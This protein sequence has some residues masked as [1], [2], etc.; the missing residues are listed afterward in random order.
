M[1]FVGST[2]GQTRA[3]DRETVQFRGG[4]SVSS[5]KVVIESDF[6]ELG[7]LIFD[8]VEL[9]VDLVERA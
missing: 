4:R 7:D 2:K 3:S 9:T 6:V 1:L 5:E 8:E